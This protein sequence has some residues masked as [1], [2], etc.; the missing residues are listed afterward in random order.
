MGVER[1]EVSMPAGHRGL[2]GGW[3][4][5]L[6]FGKKDLTPA[7]VVHQRHSKWRAYSMSRSASYPR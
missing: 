3:M 2:E 4:G 6:R 7:L 1:V 5:R